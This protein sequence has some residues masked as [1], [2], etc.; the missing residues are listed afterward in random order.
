LVLVTRRAHR[1]FQTLFFLA[2][3]VHT[4]FRSWFY[5]DEPAGAAHSTAVQALAQEDIERAW[6]WLD[7]LPSDAASTRLETDSL[8]QMEAQAK[9]E[10]HG[11]LC[12]QRD[13]DEPR[14]SPG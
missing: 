2:D 6:K 14:S 5:L 11:Q 1:T 8:L 9:M 12:D 3:T 13:P 7:A 10:C 4:A